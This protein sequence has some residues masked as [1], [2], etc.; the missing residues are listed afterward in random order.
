V[1]ASTAVRLDYLAIVDPQTFRSVDER[2]RGPALALI[3]ARVGGTRLIDNAS[4]VIG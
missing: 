3:A 4:I 2:Y 1:E